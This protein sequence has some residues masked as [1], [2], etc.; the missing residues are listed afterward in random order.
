M[1]VDTLKPKSICLSICLSIYLSV[2]LSMCLS[3]THLFGVDCDVSQ[4]D[5]DVAAFEG[6][7]EV[8]GGDVV[9]WRSYRIPL[10]CPVVGHVL[11]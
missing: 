1:R 8:D 9:V 5:V 2:C 3:M 11:S 7:C 6:V 10:C 4:W